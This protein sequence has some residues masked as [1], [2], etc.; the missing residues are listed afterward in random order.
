MARAVAARL[1]ARLQR[2]IQVFTA[3]VRADD[4]SLQCTIEDRVVQPDGKSASGTFAQQLE[5]SVG[6]DWR[7]LCDDKPY[8]ALTALLDAA[9]EAWIVGPREQRAAAW[10]PP[11]TL[12]DRRLDELARRI[13]IAARA[14]L[15]TVDGRPCVRVT[16]AEGATT[17]SFLTADEEAR[18]VP[19]VCAL[20]E[21][22]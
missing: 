3:T 21:P 16:T 15:A 17:M 22:R 7:E 2:P 12:G 18:L 8:A 9:M 4:R 6:G 1:A 14:Q 5:D 20:L 13:R 11:A 10:T 19:A